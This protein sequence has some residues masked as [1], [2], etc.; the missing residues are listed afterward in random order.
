[1]LNYQRLWAVSTLLYFPRTNFIHLLC[2][3][4]KRK[5]I[6]H[7]AVYDRILND[8]LQIPGTTQKAAWYSQVSRATT[9]FQYSA[10]ILILFQNL[11]AVSYLSQDIPV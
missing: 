2:S 10:L 1:M 5:A 11:A 6:Q 7:A 4:Q 3:Y 9:S 8:I